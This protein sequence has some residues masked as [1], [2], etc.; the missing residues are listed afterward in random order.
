M[1]KLLN[2][3]I[4]FSLLLTSL[5][6]LFFQDRF[7]KLK[8][9]EI[10]HSRNIDQ[11]VV[12]VT[13]R[14]I[15]INFNNPLSSETDYSKDISIEPELE[16]NSWVIGNR[17]IIQFDK[18]FDFDTGYELILDESID[19]TYNLDSEGY[20]YTFKTEKEYEY[21]PNLNS[22]KRISVESASVNEFINFNNPVMNVIERD[23][24]LVVHLER[25]NNQI[26]II[27]K[28]GKIL[29]EFDY[30]FSI[31]AVKEQPISKK[32]WALTQ[33]VFKGEFNDVNKQKTSSI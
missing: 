4:I 28:E 11:K 29:E 1:N 18:E 9:N 31:L 33:E 17:L 19:N 3:I 13:D 14:N 25:D 2:T 6:L 22:I 12:S 15:Q 24:D 20:K 21:V 10:I 8:V 16:F 30:D 7:A 27:S 26:V 23:D 5:L 32:V